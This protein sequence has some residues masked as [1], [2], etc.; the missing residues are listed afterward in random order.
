M[1]LVYKRAAL[2]N[3]LEEQNLVFTGWSY[4]GM[5]DYHM[6]ILANDSAL[7]YAHRGLPI[8]Q[9]SKYHAMAYWS[10]RILKGVF[11]KAQ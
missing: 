3:G 2:Q 5:A 9:Q 7:F 6:E 10:S 4:V 1:K 11:Q 8:A